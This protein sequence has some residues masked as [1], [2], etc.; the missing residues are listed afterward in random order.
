VYKPANKPCQTWAGLSSIGHTLASLSAGMLWVKSRILDR[1]VL[2]DSGSA[3][4]RSADPLISAGKDARRSTLL[5]ECE[6]GRVFG[7]L[8]GRVAYG[9]FSF[10]PLGRGHGSIPRSQGLH[11]QG[12]ASVPFHTVRNG[13]EA[14]PHRTE[15]PKCYPALNHA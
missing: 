8:D 12:M 15:R 3:G 14:V 13:T 7:R 11:L 5:Y 9:Q 10:A 4:K 1:W 6:S 2:A